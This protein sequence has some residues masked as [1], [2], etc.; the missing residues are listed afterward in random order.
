MKVFVKGTGTEVNLTQRDYVGAGGQAAIYTRGGVAFK[1]YHDASNALPQ[2]KIA[3]LQA[4]ADPRVIKPKAV[5]VDA[6]GK[7]VGYTTDFVANAYV[8]CQLFPKVF[9]DRESI[10]HEAM[11]EL[12]RQLQEMVAN[13][14][15]A[16][17][18]IVDLNEMN[19]LVDKGFGRVFAIDVDSY[20]TSH[21]PAP[22]LMESVRDWS[23]QGHAWTPLSDWFSFGV[24]SFQM[25]TGIH[26][27][28]GQYHGPKSEFAG[29]LPTDTADDPFA[30]TRRR[31]AGNMSVFDPNVKTPACTYPLVVIPAAYRAWYETL[32]VQGK[33]CPPPSEFG[34]AIIVL[35][36]VV[37]VTGTANLDIFEIG[38]F[39]GTGYR[40]WGDGSNLV[41]VTDQGV[42]LNKNRVPVG[43]P[44]DP[45]CAFSPRSGR[46]V[47][48][49]RHADGK[50]TLWNLTDNA[51]VPFGMAA[52]ETASYDGRVYLRTT[53]HV[54]EVVLTDMGAQV[55]ATTRP[56]VNVLP[57]ATRLYS[58][59]VVQNMLGSVF[60]SLLSAPG[61]ARQVRVKELDAYKVLDAKFDSGVLMVIGAKGGKYDRLVLRFDPDD[62]YDVRVVADITPA[63]LNFVTL[64]SGICVCLTEEE[65]L[66]V[67]KA[68]KGHSAMKVV[69]D[70]TL[71][72][73]M[74]LFKQGGAVLFS[75]GGKVYRMKMK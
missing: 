46:A 21:Y 5:L 15:K 62:T 70:K 55:I 10:T 28:K 37:A 41:V 59:V 17:I 75:R 20:Q 9:R 40:V 14:H 38:D 49:Y 72:S 63:G 57:H 67:F 1:V 69:E 39:V 52:L 25:F 2:G 24:V 34:A 61:D 31:M 68:S 53:D 56:V 71:G 22:A 18:L 29:R 30:V 65:K 73:D 48:S 74:R 66:E 43:P 7:P 54:H 33:R 51:E 32:F 42:W 44:T 60:V 58:G 35:P 23:V 45:S 11:K 16:G 3:E 8:L 47:M 27:F 19:F 36:T 26:P 13:V 12:V 64:D 4:I 6:R 50:P